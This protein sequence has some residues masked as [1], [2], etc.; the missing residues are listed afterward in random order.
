MLE[1]KIVSVVKNDSNRNSI[2]RLQFPAI[3]QA[4]GQDDPWIYARRTAAAPT[5]S[6]IV[7]L[8]GRAMGID[9]DDTDRQQ[10]LDSEIHDVTVEHISSARRMTDDQIVSVQ[11][12]MQ[13]GIDLPG[14]PMAD[15][16]KRTPGSSQQPFTKDYLVDTISDPPIVSV[17]GTRDFLETVAEYLRHPIYPYYAGRYCCILAGPIFAG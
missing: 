17:H 1:K 15:G 6:A 12:Y 2:L 4:W 3:I 5:K 14:L 11:G 16:G 10:W 13:R 7:G 9:R 8:I